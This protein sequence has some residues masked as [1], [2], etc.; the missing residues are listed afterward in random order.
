ML[1]SIL[2]PALRVHHER[3]RSPLGVG[4]EDKESKEVGAFN[5]VELREGLE[6]FS[7]ALFTR[8]LGWSKDKSGVLLRKVREDLDDRNLH[9]QN[10]M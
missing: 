8:I 7:L 5:L 6:G 3:I 4:P 2:T 1:Q 10:D 9:A